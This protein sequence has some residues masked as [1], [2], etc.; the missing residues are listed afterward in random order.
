MEHLEHGDSLKY[1][2]QVCKGENKGF[3]EDFDRLIFAKLLD[4]LEVMHSKNIFHR[5]IKP[6]NIMIGGMIINLNL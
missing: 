5:V 4:G 3:G 1:I 2:T 6:D